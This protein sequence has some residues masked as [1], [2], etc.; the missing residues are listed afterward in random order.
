MREGLDGAEKRARP[1]KAGHQAKLP[2]KAR[3][4]CK[5]PVLHPVDLTGRPERHAAPGRENPQGRIGKKRRHF[6]GRGRKEPG[7][8]G[9]DGE[10]GRNRHGLG[11]MEER[12]L[13]RLILPVPTLA[14]EVSNTKL[15]VIAEA[16]R[17]PLGRNAGSK[18]P[19]RDGR[20]REGQPHAFHRLRSSFN[21][22]RFPSFSPEKAT[23]ICGITSF[24]DDRSAGGS[25]E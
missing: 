18:S 3:V 25:L 5:K 13:R 6:V 22:C 1:K 8:I 10:V 16:S 23:N 4:G 17:S 14:A 24:D 7:A 9:I 12:V 21:G 19:G 15:R 11:S 2:S 20:R